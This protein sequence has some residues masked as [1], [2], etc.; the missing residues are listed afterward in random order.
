MKHHTLAGQV[1]TIRENTRALRTYIQWKQCG[2]KAKYFKKSELE[3]KIFHLGVIIQTTDEVKVSRPAIAQRRIFVGILGREYQEIPREAIIG[4]LTRYS[5]QRKNEF[6][7]E[8]KRKREEEEQINETGQSNN[9]RNIRPKKK[10]QREPRN[11]ESK[12]SPDRKS[13]RLNSSHE[14][15][16]RM[17]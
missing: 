16:S 8:K 15:I 1:K 11:S 12:R 5:Q 4:R 6:E 17:S 7:R 14:W 2:I 3:D 10:V 13:T 9:C